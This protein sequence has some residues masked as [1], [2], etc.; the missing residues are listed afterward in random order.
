[1]KFKSFNFI[2]LF[3]YFGNPD[4]RENGGETK[5]YRLREYELTICRNTSLCIRKPN[6][7]LSLNLKEVFWFYIILKSKDEDDEK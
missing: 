5:C 6:F 1:M 4:H 2:Y 3:P 7:S